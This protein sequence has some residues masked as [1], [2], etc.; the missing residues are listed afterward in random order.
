MTAM[1]VLFLSYFFCFYEK[2]H[3]LNFDMQFFIDFINQECLFQH[4]FIEPDTILHC[5]ENP[6][7]LVFMNIGFF[8]NDLSDNFLPVHIKLN[9]F[10]VLFSAYFN[11]Q[12][13]N[14]G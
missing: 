4:Q 5:N 8:S 13:S 14:S 7:V 12:I 6:F 11:Y 10:P 9:Y 1:M 2:I 3:I